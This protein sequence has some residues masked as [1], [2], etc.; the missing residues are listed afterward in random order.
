MAGRQFETAD[1]IGGFRET[2]V[3]GQR[4]HF[5]NPLRAVRILLTP[6]TEG[7]EGFR[8][9][10]GIREI[11][12]IERDARRRFRLEPDLFRKGETPALAVVFRGLPGCGN[13]VEHRSVL[14][15]RRAFG[16][17]L[18]SR[19]AP[20]GEGF[21]RR[22][23]LEFPS[24]S[25]LNHRKNLPRPIALGVVFGFADGLAEK[26]ERADPVA[27]T[28]VHPCTGGCLRNLIRPHRL[29]PVKLLTAAFKFPGDQPTGM[30]C[31]LIGHRRLHQQHRVVRVSGNRALDKFVKLAP[32]V[33]PP[34][35][36]DGHSQV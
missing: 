20:F 16:A 8:A 19:L 26:L 11:R 1:A 4:V 32:C 2:F 30:R 33:L 36:L 17:A 23:G 15:P 21:D 35:H 34:D 28:R 24:L 29:P 5:E 9:E 14:C 22:E 18:R 10:L 3:L 25:A 6:P 13:L 12:E 27:I 7:R 31:G